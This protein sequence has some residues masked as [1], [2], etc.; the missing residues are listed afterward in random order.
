MLLFF[1]LENCQTFYASQTI[2]ANFK[3]L[4][5]V[6]A[7]SGHFVVIWSVQEYSFGLLSPIY[8]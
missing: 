4:S 6:L 1:T 2:R 3:P 7:E 8:L 5:V